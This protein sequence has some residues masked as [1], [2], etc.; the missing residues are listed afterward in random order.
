M[1]PRLSALLVIA[2]LACAAFFFGCGVASRPLNASALQPY[3][4]IW[5]T[6]GKGPERDEAMVEKAANRYLKDRIS[7]TIRIVNIDRDA[8]PGQ[9]AMQI[10]ARAPFDLCFAGFYITNFPGYARRGAF[11]ALNDPK[12]SILERYLSGTKALLGPV[13]L[14]DA[15]IDGVI[16]A[17]PVL[18]ERGHSCGF[19]LRKD[20]LVKDNLDA[21]GVKTLRDLEPL[22]LAVKR[23]E[24]LLNHPLAAYAFNSP[25]ALLDPDV[26]YYRGPLAV[27]PD[28]RVRDFLETPE[29]LDYFRTMRRFYEEDLIRRDAA[30]TTDYI[31]DLLAG[32][33]FA[34]E[35]V[36]KPGADK[37]AENQ[38]GRPWVQ[39]EMTPPRIDLG[40][41][42]DAMNAISSTS[43][44]P[45][46]AAMFL[47]LMNTDK[48]LNNLINF[49]IEGVHYVKVSG[50]VIDFAPGTDYGLR[51]GYNP[52]IAWE[53]GNQ[54]LN[55]L[56][57]N[58]DPEKWKKVDDFDRRAVRSPILGFV[59]DQ[60]PVKTEIAAL[61]NAWEEFVP[62]LETGSADP[63]V[64]LPKAIARFKAA[65]LDRVIREAQRQLDAWYAGNNRS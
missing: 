39:V 37:E 55:Y 59:L 27:Y 33:I 7:A 9:L 51:S 22:L 49:G 20:I 56:F 48:Y 18:K 38:T 23:Q 32:R 15:E 31:P 52:G 44:D 50:N 57:V 14:R 24:P 21:S 4:L 28:L 1:R 12:D 61:V 8:Y 35:W 63:E 62:G 46:R 2:V 45:F 25:I 5:Y 53:L 3:D 19:L 34:I 10:A 16:Y 42:T 6:R 54:L 29:A 64:V 30:T 26:L 11:V 41:V 17:L 47:E 40:D 58:E 60:D 36:T 43:K 65:G 13:F